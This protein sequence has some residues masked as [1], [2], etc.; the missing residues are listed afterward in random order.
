MLTV[1]LI[2]SMYR[3]GIFYLIHCL[4][5]GAEIKI[6]ILILIKFSSD[7]F[8]ELHWYARIF[9]G[10]YAR[11]RDEKSQHVMKDSF[12]WPRRAWEPMFAFLPAAAWKDKMHQS[13][14]RTAKKSS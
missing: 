6:L 5:I 11:G 2:V 9:V 1:N 7:C 13:T 14:L 4:S 10:K 3:G 12:P 8:I